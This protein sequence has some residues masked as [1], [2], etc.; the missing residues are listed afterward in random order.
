M[1]YIRGRRMWF[2]PDYTVWGLPSTAEILYAFTETV[3]SDTRISVETRQLGGAEQHVLFGELKDHRG[4]ALP[5]S[6]N[7]P[8]VIPLNKSERTAFLV[9]RGHAQGFKIARDPAAA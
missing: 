9:G 3:G 2:V 6:I 4:N 5:V 1:N 8:T 7:K